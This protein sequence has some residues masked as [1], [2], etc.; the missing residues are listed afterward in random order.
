MLFTALASVL[1]D[2]P[3]LQFLG[4]LVL[5]WVAFKLVREDPSAE[6]SVREGESLVDAVRTIIIADIVMSL[7]N[8]LAIGGVAHGDVA[9]LLFG[10]GASMPLILIG[11]NLIAILANRLPWLAYLGSGVLAWTAADMMTG[12]DLLGPHIPRVLGYEEPFHLVVTGATIGLALWL[13]LRRAGHR[14]SR[15]AELGGREAA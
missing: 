6:P 2:V 7:D 9:L 4:G 12:D 14:A 10:L 15:A 11:G 13:N 3:L 5:V 1:L 8:I